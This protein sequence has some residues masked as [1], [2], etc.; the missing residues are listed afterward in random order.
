MTA[1]SRERA[2]LNALDETARAAWRRMVVGL[3]GQ[4]DL[5]WHNI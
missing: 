3:A 4:V 5:L 2:Y 1:H